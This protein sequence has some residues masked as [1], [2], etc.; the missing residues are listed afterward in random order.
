MKDVGGTS[1]NER[2]TDLRMTKTSRKTGRQEK[3]RERAPGSG[4]QR[5]LGLRN[6]AQVCFK[7][8]MG[9]M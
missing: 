9:A 8:P 1:R 5:A 6:V 3:S 2:D 7:H 4:L